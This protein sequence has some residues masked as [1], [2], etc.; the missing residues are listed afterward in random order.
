MTTDNWPNRDPIKEIGFQTLQKASI[1]EESLKKSIKLI[2]AFMQGDLMPSD[3]AANAPEYNLYT[4]TRNDS[5]DHID[6]LGLSSCPCTSA[7]SLPA[8]SSACDKYGNEKYPGTEISLKCFCKS[9]GDSA[10]SQQVRGC[11][12]CEHDKGTPVGQAHKECYGAAG[13]GNAPWGTL[14]GTFVGCGGIPV[15]IATQ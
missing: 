4:F 12:A 3:I 15:M 1:D 6:L 7:P 8:N 13:W 14:I 10:W 2:L 11:L 9:A 5:I